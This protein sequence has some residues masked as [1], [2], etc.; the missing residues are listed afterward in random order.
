MSVKTGIKRKNLDG[1][2]N[3][4]KVRRE[5]LRRVKPACSTLRKGGEKRPHY[6]DAVL[7]G[8]CRT[9]PCKGQGRQ[10]SSTLGWTG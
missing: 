8:C 4:S 6:A 2:L 9:L 1:G 7:P 3:A 10:G 5:H